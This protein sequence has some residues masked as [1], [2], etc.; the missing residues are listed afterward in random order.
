MQFQGYFFQIFPIN[1][2]CRNVYL[3]YCIDQHNNFKL[4]LLSE[5]LGILW[6]CNAANKAYLK[7]SSFL[8]LGFIVGF[9]SFIY[10]LQFV[11]KPPRFD[12]FFVQF[13][14]LCIDKMQQENATFHFFYSISLILGKN[15]LVKNLQSILLLIYQLIQ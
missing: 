9:L 6:W 12:L 1:L 4:L 2:S 13:V 3:F 11:Y 14:I 7:Y 5:W 8:L 15:R 10:F